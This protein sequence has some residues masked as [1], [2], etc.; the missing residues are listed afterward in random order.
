MQIYKSFE[1]INISLDYFSLKRYFIF[2]YVPA[3]NTIY[4]NIFKVK[5]SYY[6]EFDLTNFDQKEFRYHNF[7][8]IE[9][10]ATKEDP[11]EVLDDL[12]RESVKSRLVTDQ[13]IGLF[14]SGG[15]DS[16]LIA[17][18]AKQLN[19]DIESYTVSVKGA[20]FDEVQKA[21]KKT[22]YITKTVIWEVSK[23]HF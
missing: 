5:N 10:S 16:T 9:N 2:S 14:L 6:H 8:N 18:Y 22:V 7:F 19:Q 4:K 13:K 15:I 21:K 1:D 17:Y 12:L 11:I 23:T 3:P 20:T